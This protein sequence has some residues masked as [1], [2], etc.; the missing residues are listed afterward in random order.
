MYTLIQYKGTDKGS[1]RFSNLNFIAF[2]PICSNFQRLANF[3]RSDSLR[4]ALKFRVERK[5]NS[6]S[7]VYVLHKTCNQAI[8][9][10]SRAGKATEMCIVQ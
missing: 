9:R 5:R 3:P 10:R 8:S 7:L 2:I 1:F 6:S 4:T